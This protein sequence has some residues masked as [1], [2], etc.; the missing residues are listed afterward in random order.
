M[1]ERE[2]FKE[3]KEFHQERVKKVK[4]NE[5]PKPC[6][7]GGKIVLHLIPKDSFREDPTYYDIFTFEE[8][9]RGLLKPILEEGEEFNQTYNFE[10]LLNFLLAKDNTCLSYVQLYRNGIIEAVEGFYFTREQKDFSIYKIEQEIML[11]TDDYLLF[12]TEIGIKLPIVCYL[13]LLGVKGYKIPSDSI[14]N[15]FLDI[16]PF[17]VEDL[18]LPKIVIDKFEVDTKKMFKISFDR[19][20]NACGY[21]RSF[22]YNKNGEFTL[23]K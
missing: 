6:R 8:K 2:I 5:T 7:E 3:I 12:Q 15:D 18:H 13:S 20:W 16:H 4:N 19:I 23:K 17:D 1:E 21:P 11:K 10:G 9:S 14:R 22:Q